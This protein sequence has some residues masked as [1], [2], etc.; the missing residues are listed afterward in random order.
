MFTGRARDRPTTENAREE[1]ETMLRSIA[2]AGAAAMLIAP[3]A[4][5]EFIVYKSTF[6]A[7][8][9]GRWSDNAHLAFSPAFTHFVGR[10]SEN[11]S[12]LLTLRLPAP[13]E[14]GIDR[15]YFLEFDFYAIDS[16]DGD[17]ANNGPDSFQVLVNG[18]SIFHETFANTHDYQ[19]FREPDAG[20]WNMGFSSRWADAIYTNLLIPFELEPDARELKLR[21]KGNVA[22]G[23]AD[24]S[25]GI[26]NLEVGYVDVPAPGVGALAGVVGLAA[27]RRRRSR[28]S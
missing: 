1:R 10:Y 3:A 19:S 9:D 8:I 7:P 16:W 15:T 11:D 18:D 2:L 5:A 23:L 28:A 12:V 27:L 6:E 13:P 4:S 17:G 20:R 26:D 25:W 14:P 24:E 21:F 22:Q